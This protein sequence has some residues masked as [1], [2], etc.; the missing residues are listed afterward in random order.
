MLQFGIRNTAEVASHMTS[1][2][3]VLQY[4]KI[5]KEGPFT[6][7]PGNKPPR[8]WPEA[9]RIT[10]KNV[11]LRYVPNEEP[12]LKNL[13]IQIEPGQKVRESSCIID[14]QVSHY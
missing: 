2:E 6:S 11:Y 3:R 14:I 9:G 4:T 5:E 7:L 1:V 12:V 10:F 13:T 8:D